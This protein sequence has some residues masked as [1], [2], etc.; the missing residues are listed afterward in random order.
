ML[1]FDCPVRPCYENFPCDIEEAG[2]VVAM[3]LTNEG[4]IINMTSGKTMIDS[5]NLLAINGKAHLILSIDGE[6]PKPETNEGP[7][8][9]L[10]ETKIMSSVH[11]I[12]WTDLQGVANIPFYNAIRKTSQL[13]DLYFITPTLIWD[14]SGKQVTVVAPIVIERDLKS[15]IKSDGTIKWSQNGDPLATSA[16]ANDIKAFMIPLAYEFTDGDTFDATVAEVANISGTWAALINKVLI[17]GAQPTV[18]YKLANTPANIAGLGLTLNVLN[19]GY[20]INPTVAGVYTFQ[21]I[22][23]TDDNCITGKLLVTITVT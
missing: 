14:V 10:Q 3:V 18:E 5:F 22:A 2:K 9:G 17:S 13:Y 4:E 19:G 23:Y 12:N 7:G 15:F 8:R 21:V 1:N 6:K 20:V 11:T 16:K